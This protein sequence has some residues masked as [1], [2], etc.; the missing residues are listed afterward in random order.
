MDDIIALAS[1]LLMLEHAVHRLRE[2]NLTQTSQAMVYQQLQGLLEVPSDP[3]SPRNRFTNLMP[4]NKDAGENNNGIFVVDD[5]ATGNYCVEKRLLPAD[6]ACGVAQREIDIMLQLSGH[7]NI[8][9]LIDYEL[10]DEPQLQEYELE[11]EP[12]LQELDLSARTWTQYCEYG[13]LVKLIDCVNI[14]NQRLSEPFLWHILAS[15]AEAVRYLQ[16]GPKDFPTSSWN[17]VYHRDIHL[18]NVLLASDP[19]GGNFPRVVLGDFGLSTTTAHTTLGFNNAWVISRFE[20]FFAPP[21]FPSY[22]LESDIYQIGAV[23]YCL[24]YGQYTPYDAVAPRLV[25]SQRGWLEHQIWVRELQSV[26]PYSDALV[27]IVSACLGGNVF[28]RC[29]IDQLL[30]MLGNV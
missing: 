13:S 12:Q 27:G 20:G 21:E 18:G 3:N 23:L 24:M 9:Q 28:S 17:A 26:I 5:L 2:P 4:I 14:T 16:H 11:D 15:L 30:G 19:A 7:P 29:N 10:K 8:I 1:Y 22:Y 25:N 6:V